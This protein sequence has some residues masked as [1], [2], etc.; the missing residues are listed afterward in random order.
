MSRAAPRGEEGTESKRARVAYLNEK[1]KGTRPSPDEWISAPPP[2]PVERGRTRNHS[3]REEIRAE[4]DRAGGGGRRRGGTECE[5]QR[6]GSW[7]WE[8]IWGEIWVGCKQNRGPREKRMERTR[9]A[10]SFEVTKYGNS[11]KRYSLHPE[12]SA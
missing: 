10:F 2:V 7:D 8:R 12:R 9:K 6:L 11:Y 5:G 3:E 4:G 1:E